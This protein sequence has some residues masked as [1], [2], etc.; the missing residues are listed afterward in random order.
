MATIFDI[1][2]LLEEHKVHYFLER[3]RP[4]TIR[5]SA[6]LVGLRLEIDVFEDGHIEVSQ[7]FGDESIDGEVEFLRDVLLR[8]S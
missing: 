7:F 2:R 5:F 8:Q 6:T 4:D 1:A 3:T